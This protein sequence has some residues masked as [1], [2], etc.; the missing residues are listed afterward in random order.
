MPI[1]G[2]LAAMLGKSGKISLTK[3]GQTVLTLKAGKY[4]FV[5]TDQSTKGG[6]VIE[7][8]EGKPKSL[9][10]IK[11]TGKVSKGAVLKPGRWMYHSAAGRTYYFLVTN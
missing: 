10:S 5:V 9:S 8:V 7:P 11:F 2:T 1:V 6:F 4:K 3:K